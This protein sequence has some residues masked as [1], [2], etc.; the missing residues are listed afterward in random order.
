MKENKWTIG[1][2]SK[3][4]ALERA[5]RSKDALNKI[6]GTNRIPQEFMVG[7]LL[8]QSIYI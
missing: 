7:Q 3:K 6:H 8:A 2:T 5:H 4:I 1:K